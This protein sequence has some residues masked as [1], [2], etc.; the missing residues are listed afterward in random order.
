MKKGKIAGLILVSI[1]LAGLILHTSFNFLTSR[2]LERELQR[3]RD[4]GQPLTLSELQPAPLADGENAAVYYQKAFAV[5]LEGTEEEQKLL[6]RLEWTKEE[7]PAV[8]NLLEKNRDT[9]WFL[10]QGAHRG[11]SQFPLDY[12]KGSAIS[13][14]HLAKLRT[15][16][17]LL[18]AEALIQAEDGQI[19]EALD[20][21]WVGLRLGRAVRSEPLL[22][23]QLVAFAVEQTMLT[24]LEK[25]LN[26]A[27]ADPAKYKLLLRELNAKK[28]RDDLTKCLR[29]ERCFGLDAFSKIQKKEV[30][31][32]QTLVSRGKTKIGQIIRNW[33]YTSYFGGPLYKREQVYYIRLF[34]K[35]ISLSQ[36]PYYKISAE[37]EKLGEDIPPYFI[38]TRMIIPA[39]RGVYLSFARQ[40]AY[41]GVAR[42]G[43]ALKIYK[44]EEG[45]YPESLNRLTP[46]IIPALPRDPFTGKDYIYRREGKGFVVYSLGENLRDDGGQWGRNRFRGEGD[47]VWRSQR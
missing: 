16:A 33:F 29:A 31:I 3:L 46:D 24:T 36:K 8:R 21:C 20:T 19:N 25:I 11:K 5:M 37:V 1:L 34:D 17:R 41:L 38:L 35:A 45:S 18:A 2:E 7:E 47:I 43:L 23:S 28:L 27:D 30:S 4:S 9:L 22:I 12:E 13:L 14:P 44:T 10:K 39:L 6:N 40:E 26:K 15:C 32:E 42:L